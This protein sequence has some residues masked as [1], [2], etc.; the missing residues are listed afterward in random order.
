MAGAINA[1]VVTMV[2]VTLANNTPALVLL[3][4]RSPGY[5]FIPTVYLLI[6]VGLSRGVGVVVAVA[7]G[8]WCTGRSAVHLPVQV[9][10]PPSSDG[11]I[12]AVYR[13]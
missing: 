3:L 6:G 2:F 4:F 12:G 8:C 7:A 5:V 13:A 11:V 9:T 10:W 1:L